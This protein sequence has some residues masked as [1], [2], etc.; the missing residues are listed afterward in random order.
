MSTAAEPVAFSLAT[1]RPK[2]PTRSE[3]WMKYLGFPAGILLFL[4]IWSLPPLAGLS[5]AGQTA[6]AAFAAALLWW[7]TEPIPT[8]LTSLVLIVT[9]VLFGGWDEKA[10]LS[11][12]G[13]DVI[14][15]NVMAFILSSMLVKTP[16]ARRISLGLIVRFGRSASLILLAFLFLQIGLAALIPATAARAVMTLPLMLSVSAL[17]GSTLDKPGRFGKAMLLQNLHAINTGSAA[18]VTGSSANLIAVA[19]IFGMVGEQVYYTDWLFANGPIVVIALLGSWWGL[20]RWVFRLKPEERAPSVEGGMEA[21][22]TAAA[23]LGPMRAEE[24]R[25]IA[26]FAGVLALW[27]SDKLHMDLFGFRISAVMAAA[28]GAILA[29]SPKVGVLK[30]NEADIPWHLMIFSAG[31]YAGGLSLRDTGAARYVVEA[32]FDGLG[33]TADLGFWTVYAVIIAI[34]MFSHIFFTSKT[35]RT[36]I[37][38]PF[39]IT[40]AQKMGFPPLALALPAAFTIDWV[41]T[42]PINAK[43]NVIFFTTGQYSVMDSLKAGLFMTTLGTALYLLA[44]V[45][46]FRWLGLMEGVP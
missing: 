35:M 33:L 24:W 29:V 11:V 46:W 5:M 17:Y 28:M 10:A 1:L 20:H 32:A 9:L 34:N 30:W 21:M 42:L 39:V 25:T 8:H 38:I 4:L 18:Y 27:M 12:L 19:F 7:T 31:A 45:T 40:L 22:R 37:M 6:L 13:L 26:I 41:N 15:L 2:E 36:L 16:L 14:W 43:P 3:R 44:G 23:E